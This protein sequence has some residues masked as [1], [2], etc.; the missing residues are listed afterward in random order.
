MTIYTIYEKQN[1][2]SNEQPKV[3]K[4]FESLASAKKYATRIQC[5]YYTVMIIDDESHTVAYKD[6]TG[7]R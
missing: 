5:L 1:I 6:S 3:V 4:E 2:N 7:W